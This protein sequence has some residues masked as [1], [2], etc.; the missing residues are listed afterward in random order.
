MPSKRQVE[1][2]GQIGAQFVMADMG[3]V[4]EGLLQSLDA[5]AR[6]AKWA[7]L[8]NGP[9]VPGHGHALAAYDGIEN[10][11][12]VPAQI[13]D[14]H[15]FHPPNVSL[16]RRAGNGTGQ[17]SWVTGRLMGSGSVRDQIWSE[18]VAS[19]IS[20]LRLQDLPWK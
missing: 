16:A 15:L 9:T 14:T 18:A 6:A 1:E 5:H 3:G 20:R 12:A 2:L 10:L 8:G 11:S 7:K 17:T 13:A 19:G 4:L